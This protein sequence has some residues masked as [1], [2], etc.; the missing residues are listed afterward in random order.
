L[1]AVAA[2]ATANPLQPMATART[3]L[4]TFIPG[5]PLHLGL[6]AE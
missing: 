3:I 2:P 5:L 1:C 4:I 6:L